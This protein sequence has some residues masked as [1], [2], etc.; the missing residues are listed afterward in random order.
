MNQSYYVELIDFF[1]I[2]WLIFIQLKI[3][4]GFDKYRK[5]ID[6]GE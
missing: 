6:W 4:N 1:L 3:H 5:T 2:H